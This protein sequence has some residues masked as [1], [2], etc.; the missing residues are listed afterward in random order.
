MNP[1]ISKLGLQCVRS[2]SKS[3]WFGLRDLA[4]INKTATMMIASD[5][6]LNREEENVRVQMAS[7]KVVIVNY[8]K[9]VWQA[10]LI[11]ASAIFLGS[12][13]FG[14]GY[15]MLIPPLVWGAARGAQTTWALYLLGQW[16]TPSPPTEDDTLPP[17][18]TTSYNMYD[19]AKEDDSII[20]VTPTKYHSS[21]DLYN[22]YTKASF[23][24]LINITNRPFDILLPVASAGFAVVQGVTAYTLFTQNDAMMPLYLRMGAVVLFGTVAVYA[25]NR[26]VLKKQQGKACYAKCLE[27]ADKIEAKYWE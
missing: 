23:N 7:A 11:P 19:Y 3:P 20:D 25:A 9:Q 13:L 4:R 6:L 1:A 8:Q 2:V 10:S 16:G 26:W 27:L 15:E 22:L 21:Q 5:T 12:N 14:W 17:S 18:Q 24:Y